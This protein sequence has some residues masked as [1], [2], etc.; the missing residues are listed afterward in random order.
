[1]AEEMEHPPGTI[2]LGKLEIIRRLGGGGMGVVYEVEH[3]LTGHRRAL[4]VVRSIHADR[5]RFMKRLLREAKVAGTLNTDHV[6]ETY[7]AGR[8]EDGSAYVLM[9]LLEGTSLYEATQRT[10][11]LAPRR[12]ANIMAQVA[13]GMAIAHGAGIVHRD[14]KPENIFL[15]ISDEGEERAKILDFGVSKFDFTEHTTRLT[16]EGTLVGTPYYM[17]PE[18]ARG[19]SVDA[20]TDVYAMGVMLYEALVGKLPFEAIAVGE[21]FF[22]IGAGDYIPLQVR[23]PD[24]DPAWF[25]I[26]KKALNRDRDQRH[27][28][29]EAL[30]RDLVPLATGSVAKRAKTISEG[31]TARTTQAYDEPQLP[32]PPK[33][34]IELQTDPE[35][36]PPA[37]E[38]IHPSETAYDDDDESGPL[39][40]APPPPGPSA[41]NPGAQSPWLWALGGAVLVVAALIPLRLMSTSNGA[42]PATADP[43]TAEVAPAVREPAL[44]E[45]AE[46]EAE[47]PDSES[48]TPEPI[49]LTTLD[50]GVR[51][52]APPSSPPPSSTRR[53]RSTPASA[54]GLD[55]NPYR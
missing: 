32:P 1:M 27:P 8:L 2:L 44:P 21:L 17:S 20:R 19:K 52:T 50:A 36:T 55:D 24:L 37:H 26:V 25:E 5:P 9:E 49:A 3:R 16:A 33:K 15:V 45:E 54:A 31:T 38:D 13:E 35:L 34:P 46:A 12:L 30:R 23:C 48:P 18:Q 43:V 11:K 39:H 41:D 28:T 4:K 29:A 51:I 7:D 42:P 47:V 22:K 6:V 53:R 14:L 40:S 10:G